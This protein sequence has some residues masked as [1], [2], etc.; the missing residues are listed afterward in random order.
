MWKTYL[1]GFPGRSGIKKPPAKAEDTGMGPWSGKI[2]LA[3]EQ[4]SPRALEIMFHKRSD[5][6][7]KP[8]NHNER[9]APTPWN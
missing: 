5:S 4:L 6:K 8:S 3:T 7:D 9:V 2:P 1:G